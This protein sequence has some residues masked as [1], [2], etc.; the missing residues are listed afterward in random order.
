MTPTKSTT[1]LEDKKKAYNAAAEKY[2]H[3]LT[4]EGHANVALRQA[5][6]EVTKAKTVYMKTRVALMMDAAWPGE[7]G[8]GEAK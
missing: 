7:D 2:D 6:K 1:S 3:A 8:K 4:M 5:R